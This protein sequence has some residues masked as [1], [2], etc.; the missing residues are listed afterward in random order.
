MSR[1]DDTKRKFMN[2]TRYT[3]SAL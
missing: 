1:L 2:K 3:C